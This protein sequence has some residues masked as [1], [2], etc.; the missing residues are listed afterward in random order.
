MAT[1]Q[2][3]DFYEDARNLLQAV[4]IATLAT[5]HDNI[6]YAALVTPAFRPVSFAPLLLLSEMSVHTR[7][8]R[9]NPSC[10]LLVAGT[11]TTENPQTAP[12]L[13]LTGK[14]APSQNKADRETY[15][16]LHPYASL[17]VDFG[18]FSFWTVEIEAVQYV[19][20]FAA[21]S[22]LNIAK[23]RTIKN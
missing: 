1:V 17:Y 2:E 5:A 10:A 11:A 12:R 23:L 16:A 6:P 19:G 7:Q 4:K 9:L 18:D 3:P 22:K 15:L 20:G 8:L 14:A 21:A 13:C